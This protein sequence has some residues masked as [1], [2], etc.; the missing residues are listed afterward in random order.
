MAWL[1]FRISVMNSAEGCHLGF[2][3][4]TFLHAKGC[5]SLDS[6]FFVLI[7]LL[8][9]LSVWCQFMFVPRLIFFSK[10]IP[11]ETAN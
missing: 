8:L 5:Q 9:L 7:N 2:K 4:T 1:C 10:L 6:M 11:H 3:M